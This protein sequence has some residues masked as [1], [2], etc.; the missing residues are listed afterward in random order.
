MV[1][2]V[3]VVV[4]VMAVVPAP[5]AVV[6]GVIVATAKH[7]GGYQQRDGCRQFPRLAASHDISPS[8]SEGRT[9]DRGRRF[10]DWPVARL[11]AAATIC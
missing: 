7:R 4:V 8:M 9:G 10:L 11:K 1:V 2:I 5:I 6:A 3:I